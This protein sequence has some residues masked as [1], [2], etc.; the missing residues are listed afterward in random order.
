MI[1]RVIKTPSDTNGSH[2]R[3]AGTGAG[4]CLQP[5]DTLTSPPGAIMEFPLMFD[6]DVQTTLQPLGFG[7]P[8]SEREAC[9][10]VLSLLDGNFY[11][12]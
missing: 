1:L 7:F 11:E 8:C 3:L 2:S 4:V 10:C 5:N 6:F 9:A 12:T